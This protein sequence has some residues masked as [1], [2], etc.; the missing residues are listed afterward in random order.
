MIIYLFSVLILQLFYDGL[1]GAQ[2]QSN[3]S[4]TTD[5]SVEISWNLSELPCSRA[6]KLWHHGVLQVRVP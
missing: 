2:P 3:V 5:L 6:F 1:R 4:A